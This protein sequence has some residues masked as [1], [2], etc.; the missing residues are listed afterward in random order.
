VSFRRRVLGYV[1]IALIPVS[2]ITAIIVIGLMA[3][4]AAAATGGC[5]GG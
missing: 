2:G 3:S 5:G 1:L 4:G